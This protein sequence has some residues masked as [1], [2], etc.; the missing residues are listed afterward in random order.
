MH[1]PSISLSMVW[2]KCETWVI[3]ISLEEETSFLDE[4][5]VVGYGTMKQKDLTGAISTIRTEKLLLESPSSIQDL[6]RANLPGLNIGL[7]TGAKDNSGLQIRGKN[8]LK[9]GSSPLIVLDGVIYEGSLSDIN[10]MDV[11]SVDVLKSEFFTIL[12]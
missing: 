11:E 3:N 7:S 2:G 8:T 6:M 12:Y 9:A 5:V 1:S 4:V 10:P